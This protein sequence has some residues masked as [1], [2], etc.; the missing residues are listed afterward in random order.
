MYTSLLCGSNR[1]PYCLQLK[2]ALLPR[3]EFVLGA[4]R[5]QSRICGPMRAVFPPFPAPLRAGRLARRSCGRPAGAMSCECV[6]AGTCRRV[7]PVAAGH[8]RPLPVASWP[9]LSPGSSPKPQFAEPPAR[10]SRDIHLKVLEAKGIG[11]KGIPIQRYSKAKGIWNNI[12]TSPK[13][14]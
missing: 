9:L 7:L 13:E 14:P 6:S 11:A 1:T 3:R 2:A 8:L 4:G 5:P 12:F 10:T